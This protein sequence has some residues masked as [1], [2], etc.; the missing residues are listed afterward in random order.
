[1]GKT[2][3]PHSKRVY[4]FSP[5]ADVL[6]SRWLRSFNEE[7]QRYFYWK[8]GTQ[9][10][11]WHEPPDTETV[12]DNSTQQVVRVG[13]VPNNN[14]TTLGGLFDYNTLFNT[15]WPDASTAA[16]VGG[17]V[18][19]GFLANNIN[20]T[21]TAPGA[22]H[23]FDHVK[24]T[25]TSSYHQQQHVGGGVNSYT[26]HTLGGLGGMGAGGFAYDRGLGAT[27]TTAPQIIQHKSVPVDPRREE[28]DR[29]R[30]ERERRLQEENDRKMAELIQKE[31]E[32]V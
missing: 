18:E 10:T 21:A 22:G 8:E 20:L 7:H 4:F 31:M 6:P 28:W 3:K 27:N 17:G 15:A 30:G 29:V 14:N 9:A 12:V 26:H 16:V 32:E 24:K 25:T 5:L 23:G 1:M 13:A 19:S 11:Q 2:V